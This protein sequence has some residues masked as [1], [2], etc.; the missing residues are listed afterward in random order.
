MTHRLY[1]GKDQ[2]VIGCD[3]EFAS[4]RGDERNFFDLAFECC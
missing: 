1:F 3:F 4:A 2:L